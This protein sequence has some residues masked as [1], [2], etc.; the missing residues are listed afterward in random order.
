MGSA[1]GKIRFRKNFLL[2]GLLVSAPLYCLG[3]IHDPK[4]LGRQRKVVEHPLLFHPLTEFFL[5]RR[6]S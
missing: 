2:R 4:L 5:Y 6:P 3:K 1:K